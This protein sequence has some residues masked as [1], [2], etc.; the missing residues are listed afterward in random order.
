MASFV[1][2]WSGQKFTK[3]AQ[4]EKVKG[5][6]GGDFPT[7]CYAS[8]TYQATKGNSEMAKASLMPQKSVKLACQKFPFLWCFS[9]PHHNTTYACEVESWCPIEID[10]LPLG[11]ERALMQ[12]SEDYTVF[13]KNSVAF[14]YFGH[15]FARNNLIGKNGR[16]CMYKATMDGN[17][18]CQIFR[19]G[20]I[21]TLAGGNFSK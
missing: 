19:L 8:C 20:D 9:R 4:S 15:Q 18:G 1:Y 12:K 11:D 5:D 2:H 13:I 16:P 3:N 6:I 7:L 10:K 21:I 14:P 17:N